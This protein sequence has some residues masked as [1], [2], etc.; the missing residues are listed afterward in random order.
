M[1]THIGDS[2]LSPLFG[3]DYDLVTDSQDMDIL[4]E[5][6]GGTWPGDWD[7]DEYASAF[8]LTGDGEYIEVWVSSSSIPYSTSRFYRIL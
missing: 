2:R 4:R 1:S 6:F 8:V 7:N 3:T 5:Y